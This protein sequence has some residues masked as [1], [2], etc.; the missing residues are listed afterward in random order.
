MIRVR[1]LTWMFGSYQGCFIFYKVSEVTL[2]SCWL[3][4]LCMQELEQR[5]VKNAFLG[6]TI[7]HTFGSCLVSPGGEGLAGMVSQGIVGKISI[8]NPYPDVHVSV[9]ER[10]CCSDWFMLLFM[11]AHEEVVW[12]SLVLMG[13]G[14]S[15]C[16]WDDAA[17]S[18][19][20]LWCPHGEWFLTALRSIC[21]S[22]DDIE[23]M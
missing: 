5:H 21:D 1:L 3:I 23:V 19:R 16:K 18:R 11:C 4:E 14:W 13:G 10:H 7:L 12:K 20:L 17:S 6:L 15:S 9:S 2:T 8:G 22:S